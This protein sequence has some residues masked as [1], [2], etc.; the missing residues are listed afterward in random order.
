MSKLTE[1]DADRIVVC[2]KCMGEDEKK[3]KCDLC[4]TPGFVNV[5]A[6]IAFEQEHERIEDG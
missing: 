4:N 3:Y 6:A 2:P 1:M 5:T